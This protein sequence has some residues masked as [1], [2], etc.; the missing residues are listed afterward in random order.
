MA[1]DTSTASSL[2]STAATPRGEEQ[3]SRS[4]DSRATNC[5]SGEEEEAQ[6][7]IA[8]LISKV[9]RLESDNFELNKKDEKVINSIEDQKRRMKSIYRIQKFVKHHNRMRMLQ[10]Y[11]IK[12][13]ESKR[14]IRK[15][16]AQINLKRNLDGRRTLKDKL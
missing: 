11:I 5:C 6:R 12:V 1:S 3:W 9:Q 4:A 15:R 10:N 7:R 8:A 14:V 13:I 16:I 2:P